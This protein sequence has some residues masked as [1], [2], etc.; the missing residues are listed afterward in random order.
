MR[1]RH[2]IA[3]AG[4]V[5]TAQLLLLSTSSAFPHGLANGSGLV[6]RNLQFHHHP[7]AVGIFDEDLRGYTG[8]E[9]MAAIDDLHPS[10]PKRGFIHGG[11]GSPPADAA[12]AG[13]N[14]PH[15]GET[16]P[17]DST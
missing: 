1:A 3:S 11:V 8:F 17:G 12:S 5:G 7:A 15:R 2:V 4:T 9:A 10:D 14:P 6:G 16:R 13:S